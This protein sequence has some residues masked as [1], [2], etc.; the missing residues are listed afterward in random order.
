MKTDQIPLFVLA[1]EF[2]ELLLGIHAGGLLENKPIAERVQ[3]VAIRQLPHGL[4]VAGGV[5]EF[6]NCTVGDVFDGVVVDAHFRT[7]FLS[8]LSKCAFGQNIC[9]VNKS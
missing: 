1:E 9:S 2:L 7:T 3:M 4:I 5:D 6:T 8:N